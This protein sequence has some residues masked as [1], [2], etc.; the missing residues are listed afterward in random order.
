MFTKDRIG[1]LFEL[2]PSPDAIFRHL[3]SEGFSATKEDLMWAVGSPQFQ[4]VC[5]GPISAR[6]LVMANWECRHSPLLRPP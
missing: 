6:N 3:P 5:R 2:T 1:R 4:Q